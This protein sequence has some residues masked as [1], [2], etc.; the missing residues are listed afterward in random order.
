ME[1]PP[2]VLIKYTAMFS[3]VP[4]EVITKITSLDLPGISQEILP[5][6]KRDSFNNKSADCSRNSREYS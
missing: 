6:V 2:I 4:F 5:R 3:G 1:I